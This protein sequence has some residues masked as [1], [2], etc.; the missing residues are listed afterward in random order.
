MITG[1]TIDIKEDLKKIRTANSDTDHAVAQQSEQIKAANEALGEVRT[2]INMMTSLLGEL[3]T[4]N[5]AA[6]NA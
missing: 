2:S 3:E 5:N 1:E 4:K 6:A